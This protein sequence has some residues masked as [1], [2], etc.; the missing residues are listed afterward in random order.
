MINPETQQEKDGATKKGTTENPV[1]RAN[2]FSK[3]LFLWLHRFFRL[4]MQRPIEEAD[5]YSTLDSH[6][7]AYIG[8]QFDKLWK[9]ETIRNPH[10][11]SFLR[12]II[13]LYGLRLLGYGLFYTTLDVICRFVTR[14]YL[15]LKSHL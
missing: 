9:R 14:L 2:V 8:G 3:L 11:A 12:V 4:G 7:A 13:Q 6:R 5:I 15:D 1:L 10:N